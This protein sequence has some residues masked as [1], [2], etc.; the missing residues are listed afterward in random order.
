MAKTGRIALFESPHQPFTFREMPVPDPKPG[1]A[2]VRVTMANICGSDL[3]AWH[4]D[5]KLTGL[6]GKLPTVLGHEMAGQIVALG[7]GKHTDG[8]GQPLHEGDHVV[9]TYFTGC[10]HCPMCL[11]GHRVSCDELSMAMTEPALEWPYFVGGYADYY[12]IKPGATIYKVPQG[13]PDE[14]VA[15]ANCALSQVISGWERAQL[16]FDETV[17]IQGAGGLGLYACAVAKAFGARLVIAVDAVQQRLDMARRF[18]ADATINLTELPDE[19]ARV[20]LVKKLTDGRGVD[21]VMELVGRADV[22]PEGLRMLGQFGRYV[23]IGNINAGQTYAA[24]P[25]RLVM[26][27]KSM[28]GVSLYEPPTLG[29]AL[30]FL[31]RHRDTLPFAEMLST[32][33]PLE[34]INEAFAKADAREVVRASIVP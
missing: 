15:G 12:Y 24:D 33:F 14:V 10:G 27:N 18:G 23:T 19:K 29:K 2:V 17:L 34:Q 11:R 25:S 22:V 13:L 21:V 16:T 28:L 6:G 30:R 8:N 31:E 26:S 5:F 9:Y 20:N 3:H 7:E 32:R 4:G 1:A